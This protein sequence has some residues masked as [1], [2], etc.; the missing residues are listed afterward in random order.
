M[1]AVAPPSSSMHESETVTSFRDMMA[2]VRAAFSPGDDADAPKH[3]V[4]AL[5]KARSV[6]G[7]LARESSPRDAP[8]LTTALV[9][10]LTLA[11]H[12]ERDRSQA[13]VLEVMEGVEQ[14]IMRSFKGHT[15]SYPARMVH[16]TFCPLHPQ[17]SVS[18]AAVKDGYDDGCPEPVEIAGTIG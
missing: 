8:N 14:S 6:W 4:V 9:E 7:D 13:K 10:A 1:I 16:V 17:P 12:V 2:T 3:L 11:K 15:V 18:A 5:E